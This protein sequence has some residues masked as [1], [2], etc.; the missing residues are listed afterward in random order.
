MGGA[1]FGSGEKTTTQN[2]VTT[3]TTTDQRTAVEGNVGTLVGPGA[4]LSGITGQDIVALMQ[5]LG[6]E[7]SQERTVM[8]NLA[9]NLTAGFQ[10]ATQQVGD[11][12]AAT[13]SPDSNALSQLVPIMIILA[14][15]WAL[16]G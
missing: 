1:I 16:K 3:T 13:K 2:P 7:H 5:N 4:T 10:S 14:L 15:L 6:A 8:A 12:L 11:I 9:S